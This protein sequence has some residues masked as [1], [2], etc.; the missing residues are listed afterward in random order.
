M[1]HEAIPRIQTIRSQIDELIE[2]FQYNDTVW[3]QLLVIDNELIKLKD[4]L[5]KHD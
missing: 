2:D 5:M 3:H 4:I 1:K